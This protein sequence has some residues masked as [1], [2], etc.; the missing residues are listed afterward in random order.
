MSLTRLPNDCIYDILKYLKNDRTTLFNCLFVN[1]F[2]CK[3]T[4]PLLYANPFDNQG[5]NRHLIIWTLT[6]CF[7]EQE[8]LQLKNLL[9]IEPYDINITTEYKPLFEYTKYLESVNSI[10]I[11]ELIVTWIGKVTKEN[12]YKYY[13]NFNIIITIYYNSIIRQCTNIKYLT[14]TPSYFFGDGENI[15]NFTSNLSKLRL[16]RL[17]FNDDEVNNDNIFEFLQGISKYCLNILKLEISLLNFS[18]PLKYFCSI[19]Q[20][21]KNLKAFKIMNYENREYLLNDILSFLELQKHSLEF[22]EFYNIDFGNISFKNFINLS[23]LKYLNFHNCRGGLLDQFEILKFASFKLKELRFNEPNLDIN[24]LLLLIKYLG[25]SLQKLSLTK[26]LT[27][28]IIIEN[29]LTYCSNLIT[30]EIIIDSNM[31]L[32]IFSYFKNLKIRKLHLKFSEESYKINLIVGLAN[33]LP[34][35][36]KE[37][38]FY[39]VSS[40]NLLY[41]KEFL[42]N[43]HNNLEIINSNYLVNLEFLEIISYYIEKINNN[44]MI[45]GILEFEKQWYD[46]AM[47]TLDKIKSYGVKIDFDRIYKESSYNFFDLN[48]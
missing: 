9:C 8:T 21:Q 17:N 39:F 47:I 40:F 16:L 38:S 1:R 15:K 20:N 2:W 46:Y 30:L 29:I 5:K 37:I 42:K 27:I 34:I 25:S 33:N 28:P 23:N 48:F 26:E 13:K 10:Q 3:E 44:L 19:I 6:L 12:Y 24:I 43:C 14:I 35:S 4:V 7:D 18:I 32:S 11:I 22:V 41:F 31:D 45:L 36:V